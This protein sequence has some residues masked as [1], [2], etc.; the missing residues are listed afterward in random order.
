LSDPISSKDVLDL[1]DGGQYSFQIGIDG[2]I[3]QM[4]YVFIGDY[5]ASAS[6]GYFNIG[7]EN[8]DTVG[9]I[10][11]DYDPRSDKG[12][13]HPQ[14]HLHIGNINNSR[15][16]VNGF[17]SPAQ[18]IEFIALSFYPSAYESLRI[19]N[20]N[21]KDKQR[22][23]TLNLSTFEKNRQGLNRLFAHLQIPPS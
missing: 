15:I 16:M 21:V 4:Y 5:L 3:V 17:P 23:E 20:G 9:W 12:I 1:I 10:R 19:E 6:L 8:A 2:S 7:M 11:L 18:F 22:I 14:C 13:L